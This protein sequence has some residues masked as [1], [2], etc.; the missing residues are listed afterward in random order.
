[1]GKKNFI[2]AV[3]GVFD[4]E[5]EKLHL[6]RAGHSSILLLREAKVE[7]ILPG[8]VGLGLTYSEKFETF[9]EE[10]SLQLKENDIFV[11]YTDGVTEAKDENLNDFGVLTLKKI[12]EEFQAEPVDT[13]AKKIMTNVSLFSRGTP[14]HDDITLLLFKWKNNLEKQHG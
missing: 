1:L 12:I 4:F 10:Y 14:Q 5:L 13:I 6:S 11:L 9:L 7:E 8:G 3:F 2:T